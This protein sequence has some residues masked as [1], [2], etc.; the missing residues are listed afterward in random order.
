MY[1][2][3]NKSIKGKSYNPGNFKNA[4]NVKFGIEHAN[5]ATLIQTKSLVFNQDRCCLGFVGCNTLLCNRCLL[6][7]ASRPRSCRVC[8]ILN[9]NLVENFSQM[10]STKRNTSGSRFYRKCCK[11]LSPIFAR[12]CHIPQT[13]ICAPAH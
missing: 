2:K 5:L 7:R 1:A 11:I 13:E 12:R 3:I 6:A 8:Y 10:L 9:P 4:K